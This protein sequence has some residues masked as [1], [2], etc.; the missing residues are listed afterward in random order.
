M[1]SFLIYADILVLVSEFVMVVILSQWWSFYLSSYI[2]V[3]TTAIHVGTSTGTIYIARHFL[4]CCEVRK[5]A[6]NVAIKFL[7]PVPTMVKCQ[8]SYH[9]KLQKIYR[10]F[11]KSFCQKFH[12]SYLHF[13]PWCILHM[14][15]I[16]NPK[17]TI[18]CFTMNHI[19]YIHMH[20]MKTI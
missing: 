4:W 7:L 5:F 8:I 14:S 11:S 15:G 10:K 17:P 18:K 12:I 9:K 13:H 16:R 1:A 6:G 20:I 2:V 3:V 19:G